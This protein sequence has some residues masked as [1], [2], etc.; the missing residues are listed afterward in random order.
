L[1]EGEYN[2]ALCK[3]WPGFCFGF[4]VTSDI[5]SVSTWSIL[6]VYR[7]SG[8]W[9]AKQAIIQTRLSCKWIS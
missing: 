1:K 5:I 6:Q 4:L 2:Y 3:V 8:R 7:E 9:Y